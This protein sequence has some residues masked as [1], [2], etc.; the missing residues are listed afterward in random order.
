M[1]LAL[2]LS[3]RCSGYAVFDTELPE[4]RA[5]VTHDF[6]FKS[7]SIKID[8][9][10]GDDWTLP[11]ITLSRQL[12]LIIAENEIT[13]VIFEDAYLGKNPQT[14]KTLCRLQGVIGVLLAQYKLVPITVQPSEWRR[15]LSEGTGEKFNFRSRK[16]CKK[17]AEDWV[18]Q[19]YPKRIFTTTDECEAIAI[20][21]S[22]ILQ[23]IHKLLVSPEQ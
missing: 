6:L 9:I 8:K 17:A 18:K 7:G 19:Q 15:L 4:G 2:D 23:S 5:R 3:T 12:S 22:A 11:L 13:H 14:F 16:E 21:Y 1:L 10:I 20:G